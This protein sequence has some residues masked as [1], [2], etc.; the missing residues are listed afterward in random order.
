MESSAVKNNH[1]RIPTNA[2]GV[3]ARDDRL[4]VFSMA[5]GRIGI[6]AQPCEACEHCRDASERRG[7]LPGD[8]VVPRSELGPHRLTKFD[9]S[10]ADGGSPHQSVKSQAREVVRVVSERSVGRV[11]CSLSSLAIEVTGRRQG[12]AECGLPRRNAL[13]LLCKLLEMR[14]QPTHRVGKEVNREQL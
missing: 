9:I 8:A 5:A 13:L 6:A 3:R 14:D 10:K 12:N 4:M 11:G 7:A 2:R 1:R